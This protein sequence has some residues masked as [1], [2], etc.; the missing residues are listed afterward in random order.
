MMEITKKQIQGASSGTEAYRPS[1]PI[2]IPAWIAKNV[3]R[4]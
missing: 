4:H 2:T 1:M 3:E